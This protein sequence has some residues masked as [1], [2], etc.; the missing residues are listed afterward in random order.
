[1]TQDPLLVGQ[2]CFV[3]SYLTDPSTGS[4]PTTQTPVDDPTISVSIYK[5]DGTVY[6]PTVSMVHQSTGTYLGTFTPDVDGM[7]EAVDL[8]TTT[9]A[10]RGRKRFYVA[11]V[12]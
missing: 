8:S 11:P 6:S 5:P 1:M 12:P 4:D 7:W 2:L 3:R 10:G 9:A